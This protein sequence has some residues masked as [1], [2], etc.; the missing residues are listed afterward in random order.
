MLAALPHAKAKGLPIHD[1]VGNVRWS[2]DQQSYCQPTPEQIAASHKVLALARSKVSWA[3]K[4]ISSW[5]GEN[6]SL[7]LLTYKGNSYP[8]RATVDKDGEIK[9]CEQWNKDEWK[10]LVSSDS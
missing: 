8:F 9:S 1:E 10:I 5:D 6:F 2:P 3:D 7:T 4:A